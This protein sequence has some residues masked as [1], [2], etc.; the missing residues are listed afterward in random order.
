MNMA[1]VMTDIEE[2]QTSEEQE[3]SL[4]ELAS[5]LEASADAEA[6]CLFDQCPSL[7]FNILEEESDDENRYLQ[8]RSE[9]IHS[10][11][12]MFYRQENGTRED[13]APF[14]S[15]VTQNSQV[16]TA[17]PTF[18]ITP[19]VEDTTFEEIFAGQNH[20][21]QEIES[22]ILKIEDGE[23]ER[24]P[25]LLRKLKTIKDE[26][27]LLGLPSLKNV[28]HVLAGYLESCKG[29]PN[30]TEPLLRAH[31]WMVEATR[32]YSSWE[33]P[34]LSAKGILSILEKLKLQESPAQEHGSQ[35]KRGCQ[36]GEPPVVT[37]SSGPRQGAIALLPQS[38]TDRP[39]LEE[40]VKV[41]L[42]W[43]DSLLDLI[44]ELAIV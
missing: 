43:V 37:G 6:L 25:P 41:D 34:H 40:T 42:E 16:N 8:A 9:Q 17:D 33:H 15:T 44:D 31:D 3:D 1:N 30:S 22:D 4:N 26:A 5:L 11:P 27:G 28:C 14:D 19:Y 32:Y 20:L 24:L 36:L 38:S 13:A 29:L 7:L 18:H 12:D 2:G 23:L 35:I 39:S 10:L 21:L